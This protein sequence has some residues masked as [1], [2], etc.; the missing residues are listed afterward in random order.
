MLKGKRRTGNEDV[1]ADLQYEPRRDEI[2][3]DGKVSG[4]VVCQNAVRHRS[5]VLWR[6]TPT[7]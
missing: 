6:N 3:Q 5:G 4:T 7:T 1:D 2:G